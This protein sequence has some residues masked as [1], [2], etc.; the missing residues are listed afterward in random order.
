[1]N[2][3]D[4][5]ERVAMQTDCT[6]QDTARILNAIFGTMGDAIGQGEDIILSGFGHFSSK[7]INERLCT[8]PI[9][10]ERIKIPSHSKVS[11]KPSDSLHLY[12]KKYH[13]KTK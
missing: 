4:L 13:Y 3:T 12:S 11:F 9:T 8:H 6:K 10:G 7:H 1:M 2:K 5:I